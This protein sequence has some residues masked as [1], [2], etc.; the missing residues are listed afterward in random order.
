MQAGSTRSGLLA[1]FVLA[2]TSAYAVEDISTF[3]TIQTRS[4]TTID[5]IKISNPKFSF[6]KVLL[7]KYGGLDQ[8]VVSFDMS[9]HSSVAIQRVVLRALLKTD[10]RA[11]PLADP[12]IYY[13]IPGGLQP[14]ETKCFDLDA[15]L[16]GDWSGVSKEDA[17]GAVFTLTVS[18]VEDAKGD[19]IVK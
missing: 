17:R 4:P 18:A 7:Q 13:S 15:A 12:V 16:L 8:R 9:N 14:G 6:R 5:R 11:V 1:A 2:A 3:N 19:R 10:K